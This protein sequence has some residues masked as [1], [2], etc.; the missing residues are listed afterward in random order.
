MTFTLARSVGR[1]V[2]RSSGFGIFLFFPFVSRIDSRKEGRKE[3]GGEIVA[4]HP[5]LTPAVM[6]VTNFLSILCDLRM[7]RSGVR[8]GGA[9]AR[10][11][12]SE[13]DGGRFS[14]RTNLNT[15]DTYAHRNGISTTLNNAT[16]TDRSDCQR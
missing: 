2:G 10:A 4:C 12:G 8:G 11:K 7:W 15:S 13:D 6:A 14:S 9:G 3:G 1:R 16:M 5:S